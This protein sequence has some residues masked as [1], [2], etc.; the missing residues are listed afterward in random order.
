MNLE[1]RGQDLGSLAASSD[2]A[3]KELR[4]G[5]AAQR[6]REVETPP[7][8]SCGRQRRRACCG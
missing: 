3:T 8:R 6:W 5:D 7:V 2:P 4:D 1:A